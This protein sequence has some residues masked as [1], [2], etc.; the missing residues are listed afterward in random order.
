MRMH[1]CA[2][3]NSEIWDCYVHL[4]LML[5]ILLVHIGRRD[6]R[7]TCLLKVVGAEGCIDHTLGGLAIHLSREVRP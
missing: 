5:N 4:T 6:L 7:L 3:V 1:T 2:L